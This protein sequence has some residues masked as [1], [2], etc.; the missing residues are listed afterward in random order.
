MNFKVG[1]YVRLR[2]D[3]KF[4]GVSSNNPANQIGQVYFLY[5]ENVIF[6]VTIKWGGDFNHYDANDLELAI[7]DNKLNRTLYPEYK[8][9]DGYLIKE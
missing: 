1:D 3:S 6:P 8:P 2:K 4:Y 9:K 7:H 5:A